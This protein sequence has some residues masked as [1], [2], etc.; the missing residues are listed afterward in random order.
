MLKV[1]TVPSEVEMSLLSSQGKNLRSLAPCSDDTVVSSLFAP[2]R[3][4][5][6][7]VDVGRRVPNASHLD[8]CMIAPKQDIVVFNQPLIDTSKPSHPTENS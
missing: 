3:G 8:I 1:G 2:G 5:K 6:A 4:M 7:R